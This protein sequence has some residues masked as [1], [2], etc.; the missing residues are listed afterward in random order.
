MPI[1]SV[2]L[3]QLRETSIPAKVVRIV[4]LQNAL[5]LAIM[6]KAIEVIKGTFV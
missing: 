4:Q 6:L 5:A 2:L 1:I 3:F